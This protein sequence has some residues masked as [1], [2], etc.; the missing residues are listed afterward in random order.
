MRLIVQYGNYGND[1]K[2]KKKIASSPEWS[3][4][5]IQGKNKQT[6]KKKKEGFSMNQFRYD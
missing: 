6:A 5:N 3:T 4:S 2:K 1:W